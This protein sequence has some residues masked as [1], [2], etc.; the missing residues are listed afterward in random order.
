MG[1]DVSILSNLSLPF[2]KVRMGYLSGEAR[3]GLMC[4]NF[5]PSPQADA[6]IILTDI[7]ILHFHLKKAW[8]LSLH[9]IIFNKIHHICCD[10]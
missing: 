6:R 8:V 1:A 10:I 5:C 7:F 2:G 9:S 3:W 4:L